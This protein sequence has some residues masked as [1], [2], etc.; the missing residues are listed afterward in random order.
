MF[1]LQNLKDNL[2]TLRE[3]DI[4]LK[5]KIEEVKNHIDYL[6]D[7]I[8]GEE[9]TVEDNAKTIFLL[10]SV[11]MTARDNAKQHFE[12]IITDAL[13]FV[14]QDSDY[15]FIIQDKNS[16]SK[17]SYEF[18]VESTVNGEKC[19]Q[20]PEEANGGGFID[21]ISV[22]AKYAYL[23]IFND[24]KIQSA[25]VFCDEPGK[26]ISADMSI[27]FAEYLK[28]LGEHYGRQII[29]ITHNDSIANVA[30]KTFSVVK[31]SNGVSKVTDITQDIATPLTDLLNE[32]ERAIKEVL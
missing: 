27:K 10:T 26:M 4:A 14:T 6:H 19:L 1:T 21:I 32:A 25:T 28:F 15:K 24:P 9:K 13:Q 30:S 31:E 20:R 8:Q 11:A 12:K 22:A 16:K 5:T 3:R 23:E 29:M 2:D 17:A 7:T 18:F